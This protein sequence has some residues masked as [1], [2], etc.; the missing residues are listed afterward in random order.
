MRYII[1]PHCKKPVAIP[2][3]TDENVGVFFIT[4]NDLCRAFG[5]ELGSNITE[6]DRQPKEVN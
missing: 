6:S 2:D 5:I 4:E 1:C 3:D